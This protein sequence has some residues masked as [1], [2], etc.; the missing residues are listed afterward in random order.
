MSTTSAPPPSGPSPPN[1]QSAEVLPT[2]TSSSSSPPYLFRSFAI[3]PRNT[4]DQESGLILVK[5][6]MIIVIKLPTPSSLSYTNLLKWLRSAVVHVVI[7]TRWQT[8]TMMSLDVS[9]ALYL[10]HQ[11][12]T[13]PIRVGGISMEKRFQ[14]FTTNVFWIERVPNFSL[15]FNIACIAM[16]YNAFQCNWMHSILVYTLHAMRIFSL[17]RDLFP[18]E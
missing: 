2:D 5:L 1:I 17:P 3:A 15:Y 18:E 16:H 8:E 13:L 10:I 7:K 14:H 6:I 11:N 12:Q 9:F 4:F